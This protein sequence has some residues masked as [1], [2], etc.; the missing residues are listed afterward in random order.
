MQQVVN[1]TIQYYHFKFECTLRADNEQTCFIII[2][3][4]SCFW[5]RSKCKFIIY[6][7]LLLALIWS[8]HTLKKHNWLFS[9]P[10]LELNYE[11]VLMSVLDNKHKVIVIVGI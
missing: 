2:H 10:Q 1:V 3:L 7:P 4:K 6:S 11:Y 9:D 8:P 5:S